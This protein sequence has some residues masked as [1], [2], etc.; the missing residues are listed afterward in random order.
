MEKIKILFL[1]A[2]PEDLKR[3]A[4]DREIREIN[5]KI[6]AAR[7]RDDLDL[8][9]ILAV[10][11]DD[12]IQSLNEHSPH[13]VHFSGH[14]SRHQEIFLVDENDLS[15][16]VDKEALAFLFRTL[17]DNIRVVVLNACFS[18][19]QAEALRSIIDCTVGMTKA[20]GD[21]AAIKFSASFYRAIG[22]GRSVQ[23]A[24]DQAKA[25]LLLE[26]IP[27]EK[28]PELLVRPGVDASQVILINP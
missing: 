7:H 10:R 20:I 27:E 5:E 15:K 26:G 19:P 28:T 13:V 21:E 14:G 3:L 25:S 18:R 23:Q 12:L 22:F 2:N 17:K 6:R 1:S 4:L 11:A 9:P 16:P 24:F 8:I